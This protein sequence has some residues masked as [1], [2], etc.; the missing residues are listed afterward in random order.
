MVLLKFIL[1]NHLSRLH[2]CYVHV[3]S[4]IYYPLN[5]YIVKKVGISRTVVRSQVFILAKQALYPL[6]NAIIPSCY[7]YFGGGVSQTLW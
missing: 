4:N 2:S 1:T 5:S 6:S 7:H 3:L